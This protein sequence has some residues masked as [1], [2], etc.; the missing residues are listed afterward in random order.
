[1]LLI[2]LMYVLSYVESFIVDVLF[3]VINYGLVVLCSVILY[4]PV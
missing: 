1:M 3:I 2:L 4:A